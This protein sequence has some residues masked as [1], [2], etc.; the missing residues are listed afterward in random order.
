M[1]EK[2]LSE[3]GLRLHV[4]PNAST[5]SPK[6]VLNVLGPGQLSPVKFQA[7]QWLL[8]LEDSSRVADGP[9]DVRRGRRG[10]AGLQGF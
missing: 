9:G 7:G 3:L 10:L 2:V 8:R 6:R 5:V 1:L 4:G